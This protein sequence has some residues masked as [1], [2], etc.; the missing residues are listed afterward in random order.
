MSSYLLYT[1]ETSRA[2]G[3]TPSDA[4]AYVGCLR[5]RRDPDASVFGGNLVVR[6]DAGHD[7][8]AVE[9]ACE[10][11]GVPRYV[12]YTANDT[13]DAAT[14]RLY[15]RDEHG[16]WVT[17]R[18]VEAW[19]DEDGPDAKY[20]TYAPAAGDDVPP[21]PEWFSSWKQHPAA[22]L[23]REH[24]FDS[25]G[26]L[27]ATPGDDAADVV[28]E[29]PEPTTQES[30]HGD[31]A[32]HAI[33]EYYSAD[34][35]PPNPE[36]RLTAAYEATS[37]YR[38]VEVS[39][40]TVDGQYV[41]VTLTAPPT[42]SPRKAA[43]LLRWLARD[44]YDDRWDDSQHPPTSRTAGVASADQSAEAAIQT[45]RASDATTYP[46]D[47]T[48][49]SAG[50]SPGTSTGNSPENASTRPRS[51]G[52]SVTLLF[53]ASTACLVSKL[54]RGAFT[55]R[56]LSPTGSGTRFTATDTRRT[57]SGSVHGALQSA[58]LVGRSPTTSTRSA[59]D[60]RRPS[61]ARHSM[62]MLVASSL[63]LDFG[64]WTVSTPFLNVAVV[65]SLSTGSGSETLRLME[66]FVRSRWM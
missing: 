41:A 58:R 53:I 32:Y 43:C 23:Q 64:S 35:V 21:D 57:R 22:V 66:R 29:C 15:A 48:Y 7:D 49:P 4:L 14:G 45:V 56:G 13:S 9:H 33:W 44:A 61:S 42:L 51:G 52:I 54:R 55:R 19:P 20:E 34:D 62:S 16:R 3:V 37:G 46:V 36:T 50:R 10:Y 12:K 26:Y 39:G 5:R 30:F 1:L 65:S 25:L 40:V 47:L 24:D 59:S 28:T 17:R 63:A 18:D 6:A 38:G 27:A 31:V 2:E 60:P 11:L 8:A